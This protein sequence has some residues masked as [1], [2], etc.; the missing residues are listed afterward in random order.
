MQRGV[1]AELLKDT[2]GDDAAAHFVG[3]DFVVARERFG[4]GIGRQTVAEFDFAQESGIQVRR[5]RDDAQRNSALLT[6]ASQP[7]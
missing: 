5:R 6:E 1:I 3:R 7:G 4:L 2:P